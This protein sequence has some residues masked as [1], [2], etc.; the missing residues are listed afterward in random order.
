MAMDLLARATAKVVDGNGGGTSPSDVFQQ[1]AVP[2]ANV[3][4]SGDG[5]GSVTTGGTAQSLFSTAAPANGF[6]IQNTSDTE[7]WV[8]DVATAGV[9]GASIYLAPFSP[10]F[11]T[12]WGY[13]PQGVVTSLL[14]PDGQNLHWPGNGNDGG[15][16]SSRRSLF[17]PRRFRREPQVDV[18]RY[19]PGLPA[20]DVGSGQYSRRC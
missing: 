11:T 15:V 6:M 16:F 3:A 7:M 14:C 5:S 9:G 20:A 18:G 19:V 12:P 2:R 1:A 13:A 10:P 17:A 8:N 4:T